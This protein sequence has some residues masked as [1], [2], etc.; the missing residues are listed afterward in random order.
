MSETELLQLAKKIKTYCKSRHCV[1][2][3][4]FAY[5]EKGSKMPHCKLKSDDTDATATYPED[6]KI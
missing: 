5:F 6:W 1:E 3:C 4:T 2:G